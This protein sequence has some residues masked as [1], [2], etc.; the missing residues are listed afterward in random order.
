MCGGWG[1]AHMS[2]QKGL[3]P[4]KTHAH[5]GLV[6]RHPLDPIRGPTQR[7][8]HQP[9]QT[10]FLRDKLSKDH[11]NKRPHQVQRAYWALGLHLAWQGLLDDQFSCSRSVPVQSLFGPC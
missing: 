5:A 9:E 7:H 11:S 3:D 2:H 1:W 8:C 4:P 10:K 6:L